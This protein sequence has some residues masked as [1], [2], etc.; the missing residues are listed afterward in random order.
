VVPHVRFDLR[1]RAP[2]M[3]LCGLPRLRVVAERLTARGRVD[4]L[5]LRRHLERLHLG[6]VMLSFEEIS[7]LVP[8][9]LPHSAYVHRERWSNELSGSHV[10]ARAW[11]NAGYRAGSKSGWTIAAYDSNRNGEREERDHPPLVVTTSPSTSR[12]VGMQQRRLESLMGRRR[13][14]RVSQGPAR[15]P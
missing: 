3:H 13:A 12:R 14:I 8:G 11:L 4:V 1:R 5:T 2:P 15:A 6:H 7:G 10:Q 9:G